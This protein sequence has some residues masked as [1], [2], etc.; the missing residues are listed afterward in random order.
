MGLNWNWNEKVGEVNFTSSSGDEWCC[1]L[2]QGNAFLIMIHEFKDEDGADHYELSGYFIDKQHCKNCFGLNKKGGYTDN[3]YAKGSFR[4]D[5]ITIYKDRYSYTKDLV[6]FIVQ[7][8]DC[9]NIQIVSK[10]IR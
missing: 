4:L 3:L 7:A 1:D 5:R 10:G 9:V 2:Y 8:F 6:S